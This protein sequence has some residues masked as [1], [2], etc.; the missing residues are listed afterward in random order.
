MLP[1]ASPLA[2]SYLGIVSDGIMSVL[3]ET[4]SW[5]GGCGPGDDEP[6]RKRDELRELMGRSDAKELG[7]P[8]IEFSSC[9]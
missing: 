3:E 4:S 7:V 8:G 2:G 1:T 9:I 5:S 6:E